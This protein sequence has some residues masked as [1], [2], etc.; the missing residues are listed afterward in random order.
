MRLGYIFYVCLVR[1]K[2]N[3]DSGLHGKGSRNK[4]IIY[5]TEYIF[6]HEKNTSTAPTPNMK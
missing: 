1:K 4:Y 3:K 6:S 5:I 2:K